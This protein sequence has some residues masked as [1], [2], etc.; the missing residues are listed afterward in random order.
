[1]RLQNELIKNNRLFIK[2]QVF[3]NKFGAKIV[4]NSYWCNRLKNIKGLIIE[5]QIL[6]RSGGNSKKRRNDI[7]RKKY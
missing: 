4:L 3:I 7:S 1:M 2:N 6:I 5:I